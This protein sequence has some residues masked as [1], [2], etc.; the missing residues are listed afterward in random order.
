[1]ERREVLKRSALIL[2]IA[3]TA[4]TAMAV[5]NGCK[6]SPVTNDWQPLFFSKEEANTLG[7]IADR[8]IPETDTPGARAAGV[9]KFM[10]EAIFSNYPVEHQTIF[11]AKLSNF[12]R[13]CADKFDKTF[14]QLSEEDQDAFLKMQESEALEFNKTNKD[15]ED[16]HIWDSLKEMTVAGYTGSEIG[17]T[18]FLIFDPIPGEYKGC[19]D[20]SEVGGTWAI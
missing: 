2:G 7:D 12:S 20:L 17:A 19:I 9:H 3:I 16:Y 13:A 5:L 18:Q 10:D 4:P 1:M 8:I 6:A 11:K 14:T 15:K